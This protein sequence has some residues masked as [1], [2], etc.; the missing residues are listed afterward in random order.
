MCCHTEIEVADPAFYLAQSQYT[1]TGPISPTTDLTTPGVWQGGYRSWNRTQICRPRGGPQGQQGGVCEERSHSSC[2]SDSHSTSYTK[3]V[4]SFLAC[5]TFL[6]HTQYISGTDL[7]R[8]LY[9]LPR[10]DTGTYCTCCHSE[11]QVRI[12]PTA[13]VRS[14]YISRVSD[15]NGVYLLYI[16]VDIHHSGRKPS[17]L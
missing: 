9:V 6:Q 17:I 16:I 1:D 13:T 15:Q 5:L 4:L 11:I 8:K 2:C 10:S 3:L 12:V 7:L 14:R